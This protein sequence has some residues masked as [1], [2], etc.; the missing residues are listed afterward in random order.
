M[1]YWD[2]TVTRSGNVAKA[3]EGPKIRKSLNSFANGLALMAYPHICL[4]R[5][6]GFPF[7]FPVEKSTR[8]RKRIT[9]LYIGRKGYCSAE[10][11]PTKLSAGFTEG[12]QDVFR[13]TLQ[14]QWSSPHC[15]RILRPCRQLYASYSSLVVPAKE[16]WMHLN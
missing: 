3:S 13:M 14:R 1:E 6:T 5:L 9:S 4:M 10:G 16:L 12:R 2:W 7:R 8:G 15:Y 11:C